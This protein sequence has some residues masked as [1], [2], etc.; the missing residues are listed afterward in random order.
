MVVKALSEEVKLLFDGSELS[1]GCS[2]IGKEAK[3]IFM[4]SK[5]VAVDLLLLFFNMI[6]PCIVRF[7]RYGDEFNVSDRSPLHHQ[8]QVNE[9]G[10]VEPL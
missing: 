3:N 5:E 9:K 2:L 10:D 8:S 1:M 6:D 4:E 7:E